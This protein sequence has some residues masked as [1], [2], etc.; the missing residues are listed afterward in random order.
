MLEGGEFS[1]TPKGT[2]QGGVISPLLAN[3]AL[4]GLETAVVNALPAY[5]GREAWHPYLIRYAD[6]VRHITGR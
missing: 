5:Q 3:V 6:D 4:H 1:P 2:P